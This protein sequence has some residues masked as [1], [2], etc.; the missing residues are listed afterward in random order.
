MARMLV[1]PKERTAPQN[2]TLDITFRMYKRGRQFDE[3]AAYSS[4]EKMKQFP[5][6]VA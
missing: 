4:R 2:I 6:R 1:C 3:R 5:E